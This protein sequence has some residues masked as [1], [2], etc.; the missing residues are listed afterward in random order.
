MIITWGFSILGGVGELLGGWSGSRSARGVVPVCLW[1]WK[2]SALITQL[3]QRGMHSSGGPYYCQLQLLSFKRMQKDACIRQTLVAKWQCQ[4][5]FNRIQSPNPV[6][7]PCRH[8]SGTVNSPC[9]WPVRHSG[10]A[11]RLGRPWVLM[12]S[13]HRLSKCSHSLLLLSMGSLCKIGSI[14][15]PDRYQ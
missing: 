4:K 13:P 6:C 11:Q 7:A 14:S 9:C 15:L 12:G 1:H 10:Q 5:S 3:C 8:T 2:S